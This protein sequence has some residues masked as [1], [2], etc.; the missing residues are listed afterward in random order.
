MAEERTEAATPKRRAEARKR[1]Q[2]ARSHDLTTAAVLLAGIYGLKLL[3]TETA[4][5]LR[6][7]LVGNVL[8]LGRFDKDAPLT[9][10]GNALG[11]LVSVL[12]PLLGLMAVTAVL[13]SVVQGGFVFAPG[14]LSPKFE[15]VNPFSGAKRIFS[16]QGLMTSGKTLAKFAVV[17]GAVAWVIDDNMGKLSAI[18]A[19]E[20][21]PAVNVVAGLVWDVL[22]KA[23]IA[24]LALGALDYVLER[25]RF[26]NS[27]RMTKQE[28]REEYRQSE[29]DPQVRA[30]IRRRREAL[31]REMLKNVKK[32]DVVVTNPTHFAVALQYDQLTMAAPTVVAKGQDLVA[33]RLRE[34]A[35]EAGIPVMENPPLARALYKLVP[36]G[37]QIPADLYL[38]VAEILA[39]V[40]R[41]RAE[42]LARR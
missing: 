8:A 2:S 31:F 20:L 33:L 7:L 42:R 34:V 26:L 15:R 36:V 25:R 18:G 10:G 13:V 19:L 29:G 11:L 4:G 22:F 24:M 41:L 16:M 17:A 39:F 23:A 5:R 35:K 12:P 40:F 30:Q 38:A 9:A 1:G 32:A 6:D 37:G 28:V 14:L 27:I 21:L 3:A